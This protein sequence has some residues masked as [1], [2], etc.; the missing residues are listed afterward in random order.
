MADAIRRAAGADVG[1]G[2]GTIAVP[3]DSAPGRPYGVIHVAVDVRGIGTCRRLSFNGDRAR[4]REW[5]ADAAMALVRVRLLE[6]EEGDE[7]RPQL[8]E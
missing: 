6:L 5:V 8:P 4:V 2:V 1:V 3:E 7:S